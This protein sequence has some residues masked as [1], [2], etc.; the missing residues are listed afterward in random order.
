MNKIPY[1]RQNIDQND[2]DE[3]VSTLQSDYLTQGP[4]VIEFESKF[5]KYVGANYAVA[6]NNATSGLHLSVL[7]LNLPKEI[8]LLQLLLLLR[9]QQ[10]VSDTLVQRFG[11]QTLTQIRI[12]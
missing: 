3:V 5:A 6:V 4:K 12:Y 7:S 1:G 2:I 11:L 8:E 9:L 10:T